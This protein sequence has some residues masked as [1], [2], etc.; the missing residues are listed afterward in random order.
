MIFTHG[1]ENGEQLTSQG[2]H[3]LPSNAVIDDLSLGLVRLGGLHEGT[4]GVGDMTNLGADLRRRRRRC[5]RPWL[6]EVGNTFIALKCPLE[7]ASE[8]LI[9]QGRAV[10]WCLAFSEE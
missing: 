4:N 10:S 6:I 8:L 7:S 2:R 9:E 1:L 3:I 5:G